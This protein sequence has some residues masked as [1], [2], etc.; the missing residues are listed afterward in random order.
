MAELAPW[1]KYLASAAG[2][3]GSRTDFTEAPAY[4]GGGTR[5]TSAR[6]D[7]EREEEF[8]KTSELEARALGAGDQV[9]RA[10]GGALTAIFTTLGLMT[11]TAVSTVKEIK[12]SLTFGDAEGGSLKDWYAQIKDPSAYSSKVFTELQYDKDA[13]L[14]EK[15]IKETVGFG[16]DILASGGL[17]GGLR[18]GAS[19]LGRKNT[20][21]MIQNESRRVYT[22]AKSQLADETTEQFE[23]RV[24]DF[25]VAAAA[26]YTSGGAAGARRAFEAEFGIEKGRELFLK[27]MNRRVQGG[28]SFYLPFRNR[29]KDGADLA[30]SSP[31]VLFQFN[32]GGLLTQRLAERL[33]MPALAKSA[34]K[35]TLTFMKM[36]N[37]L[38]ADTLDTPILKLVAPKINAILNRFGQ[39]SG[40]WSSWV[41]AVDR[42]A[43]IKELTKSWDAFTKTIPGIQDLANRQDIILRPWKDLEILRSRLRTTR[44]ELYERLTEL[45]RDP[46]LLNEVKE[47]PN[48]TE[49]DNEAIEL[50]DRYRTQVYDSLRAQLIAQGKDVGHQDDYALLYMVKPEDQGVVSSYLAPFTNIP[51]APLDVTKKRTAFMKKEVDPVTGDTIE[52]PMSPY[53]AKQALI[54]E[55]RKDIADLIV[56]DPYL[57]DAIYASNVAREIAQREIVRDAVLRDVVYN[58]EILQLAPDRATVEGV[59]SRLTPQQ[60]E[61]AFGDIVSHPTSLYRMFDDLNTELARAYTLKDPMLIKE[62]NAKADKLI[63]AL[64]TARVDFTKMLKSKQRRIARIEDAV[65]DGDVEALEKLRQESGVLQSEKNFLLDLTMA[66]RQAKQGYTTEEFKKNVTQIKLRSDRPLL[67]QVALGTGEGIGNDTARIQEALR[68]LVGEKQVISALERAML[69]RRPN[70]RWAEAVDLY[71]NFFRASATFGKGPGFGIRNGLGGI[72]SNILTGDALKED[73]VA[74]FTVTNYHA[75]VE[76]LLQPLLTLKR[77]DIASKR[78][79]FLVKQGKLDDAQREL[80]ADDLNRYGQVQPQTLRQIQEEILQKKLTPIP[81]SEGTNAYDLY[82]TMRDDGQVFDDYKILAG[83]PN[84][85]LEDDSLKALADVDPRDFTINASSRGAERGVVQKGLEYVLNIGPS[86]TIASRGKTYRIK[87]IQ[88]SRDISR[89]VEQWN[90]ATAIAAGLRQNGN[91]PEGRQAAAL[92]M[93]AAHFDYNNLTDT[94]RNVIRRIFMPFWTWTRYNVPQQARNVFH[95]PERVNRNLQG[96]DLVRDVFEDDN[97]EYYLPDYLVE[98]QGFIIDDDIREKLLNDPPAWLDG[99]MNDNMEKVYQELLA[100][101]FGF[102][103]ESPLFDLEKLTAGGGVQIPGTNIPLPYTSRESQLELA[104]G[105]PI[106]KAVVQYLVQKD[107]FSGKNYNDKGAVVPPWYEKIADAAMAVNSDW[108][109]GTYPDPDTGDLRADESLID[110]MRA[111]LPLLG[112]TERTIIAPLE[113]IINATTGADI[114]LTSEEYDQRLVSN[115][116]SSV[117]GLGTQTITPSTEISQIRNEKARLDEYTQRQAYKWGVSRR[118]LNDMIRTLRRNNPGISDEDVLLLVEQARQDGRL[119][120]DELSEPIQ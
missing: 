4:T 28:V 71:N 68:G 78:L 37:G 65:A 105:N 36:K 59:L 26:S 10:A 35:S 24:K 109:L 66:V 69:L 54:A 21:Q 77:E 20:A 67:E 52:V 115:L 107:L 72:Q 31:D 86:V 14:A 81:V 79:D 93:K 89:R 119:A 106:A 112:T 58:A 91:T 56:D 32:R 101:P 117:A 98:M 42:N 40:V 19:Q 118:K 38:R 84:T 9:K 82:V 25:A 90:R 92:L 12:D 108:S 49:L 46:K 94:E 47:N 114:D 33:G 8:A 85:N 50:A 76:R 15:A 41:A 39:E 62:V 99:M 30:S 16:I 64:T 97:D 87:P 116:L 95:A 53:E 2:A 113:A 51:G 18:L 111:L 6:S 7:I 29:V 103:P 57:L 3:A 48:R 5:G 102:R 44:P 27:E 1:Q 17:A 100:H 83:A 13:T 70:K 110:G 34:E 55:G 96:W 63:Y 22:Q 61:K 74:G 23:Q 120:P 80:M 11:R 43:D 88:L 73:F 60:F 45:R 75:I 104:S